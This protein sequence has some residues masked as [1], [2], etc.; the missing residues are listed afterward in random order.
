MICK[1]KNCNTTFEDRVNKKYCSSECKKDVYKTIWK[2]KRD[3]KRKKEQE[4]NWG[5]LTDWGDLPTWEP[6]PEE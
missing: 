1:N 3:L 4:G 5:P 2:E 6:P